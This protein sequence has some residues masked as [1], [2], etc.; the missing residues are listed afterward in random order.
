[1][2]RVI[3]SS[4]GAPIIC[5]PS[6]DL[7]AIKAVSNQIHFVLLETEVKPIHDVQKLTDA[8]ILGQSHSEVTGRHA[9][10]PNSQFADTAVI[11]KSIT[12]AS[13]KRVELE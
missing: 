7:Q 11:S 3:I 6:I 5:K 12:G 10:L 9:L 1:M 4:S 8:N 13:K 2:S